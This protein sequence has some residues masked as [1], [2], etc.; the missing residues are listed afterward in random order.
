MKNMLYSFLLLLL[1]AGA[2]NAAD[3]AVVAGKNFPVGQLTRSDVR[4]FFLG[5][6]ILLN[7][8]KIRPLVLHD[9]SGIHVSF[10]ETVLGVSEDGFQSYWI[11][12]VF[13]DGGSPPDT[14]NNPSDLVSQ[15][16]NN[17]SAIGFLSS[18]EAS[19]QSDL[20]TLLVISM[21]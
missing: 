13:Q 10:L 8:K 2:A 20:Q 17:D 6:K 9:T 1:A 18:D 11:R 3:I 7:G 14:L 12:K 4:D 5:E 19:A 15:L 16:M 21:N